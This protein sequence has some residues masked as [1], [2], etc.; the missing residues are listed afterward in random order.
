[1]MNCNP[2]FETVN[3]IGDEGVT[4]LSETL[5]TNTTLMKLNLGGQHKKTRI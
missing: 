2:L 1:M 5:K 3:D 4:A